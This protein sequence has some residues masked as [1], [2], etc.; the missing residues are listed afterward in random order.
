MRPSF[1]THLLV[2]RVADA[3]GHP[4]FNLSG[5]EDGMQHLANLLQGNKVIDG[6]AVGG[7]VDRDFGNVD[8]PGIGGIGFAAIQLIVPED[9]RRRLIAAEGLQLAKTLA[10][11]LARGQELLAAGGS[12]EQPAINQR[13]PHLQRRGLHES[14]R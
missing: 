6:D 12:F 5:S 2:Q 11:G 1:H 4:T 10:V 7:G 13:L 3:L 14:C 8:C 9:I